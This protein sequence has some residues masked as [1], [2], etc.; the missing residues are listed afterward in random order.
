MT[1]MPPRS[2]LV[3]YFDD[4]ETCIREL[5]N[6]GH[7][8]IITICFECGADTSYHEQKHLVKCKRKAC[9]TSVSIFYGTFFHQSRLPVHKVLE[10]G[11]LWLNNEH[12]TQIRQHL[13]LARQTVANWL[14]NYQQLIELDLMATPDEERKIGG[15]GIVV[16][17][18][19]S[20]FGRRKYNRGHRVE[21]VW[22]VGGVELTPER[23][24]FFTST[25]DRSADRLLDII[26]R[27]VHPGTI[28]HS[29]CWAGYDTERLRELGMDHLTV[30]HSETFVDR[31]TG[32]H[33]NHIEGTWRG[34]KIHVSHKNMN[35][36]MVDGDLFTFV[37]KRLHAGNWWAALLNAIRRVDY[38]D[39]EILDNN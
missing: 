7:L 31:E 9:R 28:I 11:Y 2:A 18:D 33:T 23:K 3:R 27:S 24:C 15:E 4:T 1:N 34:I 36:K 25:E 5:I 32:V 6:E 10:F 30:N 16:Q 13:G 20:K 37:W 12:S 22:V 21:G 17:I 38:N 14:Q 8:V 19:E 35:R 26:E 29:D 39:F